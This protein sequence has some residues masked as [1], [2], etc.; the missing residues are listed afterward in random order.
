MVVVCA[1]IGYYAWQQQN[2]TLQRLEELK[3]QGTVVDYQL[4]SRPLFAVDKSKKQL[5]LV[6][7]DN[8]RFIPFAD[9]AKIRFVE[10]PK[11]SQKEDNEPIAPDKVEITLFN[12]EKV[13]VFDLREQAEEAYK[14]FQQQLTLIKAEIKYRR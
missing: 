2:Q 9:V 8:T 12:G 6:Y 3:N 14:A 11:V 10:T 4:L 7:S 13:T 5:L 1:G